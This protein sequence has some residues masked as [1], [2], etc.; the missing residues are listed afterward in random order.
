MKQDIRLIPDVRG[1][2]K[3][4]GKKLMKVRWARVILC[5]ILCIS[6]ISIWSLV[7]TIIVLLIVGTNRFP[8]ALYL[9][10][11]IFGFCI[12]VFHCSFLVDQFEDL[13]FRERDSEEA[14]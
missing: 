6:T 13:D 10:P 14:K 9:L 2:F 1:P 11:G 8:G 3:E 5:I 4:F 12:G 7:C